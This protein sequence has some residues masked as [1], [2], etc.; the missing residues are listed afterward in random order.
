MLRTLR[1]LTLCAVAF[2]MSLGH[3]PEDLAPVKAPCPMS[4]TL[5]CPCH[6]EGEDAT[7]G[8]DMDCCPPAAPAPHPGPQPSALKATAPSVVVQAHRA[9]PSRSK[10]A[11]PLEGLDLRPLGLARL[12]SARVLHPVG[13]RPTPLDPPDPSTRQARLETYRI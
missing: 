13:P 10:D 4:G 1:W 2:A 8:M 3:A 6:P 7:G 9:T 11:A 12:D 5:D